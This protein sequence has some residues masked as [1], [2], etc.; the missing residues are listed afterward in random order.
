[1]R[2][3]YLSIFGW[4]GTRCPAVEVV[5]VEDFCRTSMIEWYHR[6]IDTLRMHPNTVEI[7][8]N[9]LDRF[10]SLP[11]SSSSSSN[12]NNTNNSSMDDDIHA[13]PE[14]FQLR[15]NY[16]P[17][18]VCILR[19]TFTKV[20]L[21]ILIRC[22]KPYPVIV[23]HVSRWKQRILH[24]LQ[25]RLIL[26]TTLSFLMSYMDLI[27]MNQVHMMKSTQVDTPVDDSCNALP[28]KISILD[29]ERIQQYALCLS[30]KQCQ[31]A[32]SHSSFNTINPS[33]LSWCAMM[34]ALEFVLP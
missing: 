2:H 7:V 3:H 13:N 4:I 6:V 12:T 16:A 25:W 22:P 34:N 20:L 27:G 32:F 26:P 19:L 31:W 21:S 28:T 15:A 10:M 29:D 9:N 8:I 30:S 18:H 23:L 24:S 33:I 11:A 17:W 14:T 1:M 5:V